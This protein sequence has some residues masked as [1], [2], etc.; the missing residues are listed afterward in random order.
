MDEEQEQ[1]GEEEE[2]EEE[3]IDAFVRDIADGSIV[4]AEQVHNLSEQLTILA[5]NLRKAYPLM[6]LVSKTTPLP[7]PGVCAACG[8]D[9]GAPVRAPR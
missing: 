9:S 6:D 2:E 4:T 8:K 1:A 7:F 3:E 5:Y